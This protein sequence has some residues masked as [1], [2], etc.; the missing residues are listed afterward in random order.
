MKDK[1]KIKVKL[2]E[3][4]LRMIIKVI[5]S[6]LHQAMMKCKTYDEFKEYINSMWK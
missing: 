2:S 4:K 3:K 6:T 1:T 5:L